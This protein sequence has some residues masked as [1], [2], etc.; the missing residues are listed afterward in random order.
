VIICKIKIRGMV[1][2][3]TRARTAFCCRARMRQARK[4]IKYWI[5]FPKDVAMPNRTS[6]VSLIISWFKEAFDR[7]TE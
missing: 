3:V 2:N 7:L 1:D 4:V 6:S 5:A